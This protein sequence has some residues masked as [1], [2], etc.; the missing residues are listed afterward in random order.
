MSETST[1]SQRTLSDQGKQNKSFSLAK[2]VK[3]WI[4]YKDCSY[5]KA[6]AKT[7]DSV[8]ANFQA[9]NYFP[10]SPKKILRFLSHK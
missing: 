1:E 7:M 10:P 3:F 6:D 8:M 9:G 4:S 2:S 5:W